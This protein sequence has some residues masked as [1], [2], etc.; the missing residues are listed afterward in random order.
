[1]DMN[2]QPATVHMV[3][4]IIQLLKQLSIKHAN[5]EIK[6]TVVVRDDSKERRLLLPH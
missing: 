1:M 4:Q 5:Y 3:S 6:A 2:G